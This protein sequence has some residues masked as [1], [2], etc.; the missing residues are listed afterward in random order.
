VRRFHVLALAC[1][2]CMPDEPPAPEPEVPDI[3]YCDDVRDWDPAWSMFEA[4]VVML[5][6][7][8][9]AEGAV[10]AADAQFDPAGPLSMNPALRCAARKHAL[11]MAEQDY[12]SNLDPDELDFR[13]RAEMAEYGGTPLEQNIGAA[14]STPEQLVTAAMGN[15]ELC[16]HIMDP[17]AD[18][19]GMGYLEYEGA[20]YPSYWTQVFG[21]GP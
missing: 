8:H 1:L 16:A 17:N 13:A 2:S 7:E 21:Q 14:Q 10:C 18:E 11:D 12:I 3:A 6:N 15:T 19:I 5:L 4:H 20:T 9:R